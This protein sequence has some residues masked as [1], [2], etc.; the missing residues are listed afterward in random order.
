MGFDP[1]DPVFDGTPQIIDQVLQRNK[2]LDPYLGVYKGTGPKIV[3]KEG[4]Y[5]N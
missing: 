1:T 4:S 3:D 2:R 5:M